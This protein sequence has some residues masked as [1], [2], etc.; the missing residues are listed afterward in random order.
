MRIIMRHL[1]PRQFT[2][3][4]LACYLLACP[5]LSPA[6]EGHPHHDHHQPHD[7]DA[8]NAAAEKPLPRVLILGDSISMG[9]TPHV[10]KLLDGKAVV[11]RPDENCGP[12][13]RGLERLDDWLGDATWDAIHFNFGLHDLKYINAQ[14]DR[15]S[16]D[17]GL[18]QVPVEQYQ[19]NLLEIVKRLRETQAKLIWCTTTP[20]PD[21]ALGRR[22]GDAKRYNAAAANVMRRSLGEER[23]I[24]DLYSFALA[25]QAELQRPADVHFT[26]EGSL[27]LAQEVAAVIERTLSPEPVPTETA[28][29]VVYHDQNANRVFDSGDVPLPDVRV[30]NGHDIV[31]T[32]SEGRYELAVTSDAVVFVIKPRGYRTP[33]DDKQ[34]PQFYYVHKPNGSPQ[35]HFVG[36][37][38]TGPLPESIDFPLYP[39][40]EPDQFKAIMFG[41]PQPRNQQEVDFMA[42]DVIEELV[43]TDA[44][45]GVTLGD[46]AFDNLDVF[47]PQARAIALLGIPWYNVIGNHDINYDAKRDQDSD[48][49]FTRVFGPNYYSF[50]YG[51]V[52]FLVLDDIEWLIDEEGEGRYQGGLGPRQMEFIR[53]DLAMIPQDQL[54]VLMMHIPLVNVR[55]RE[56][57]FRLIEKRPFCMSISAH[58]H[59]HQHRYLTREDG[60]RGPEPHHHVINVTVSGSW[61]AGL[62]DDRGIPHT[63]MADGGPNGYSVMTFD[64]HRYR[65]DFKAAGRNKDYQIG[66]Y[67]PEVVDPSDHPTMDVYA[68]V[69]NGSEK[70]EVLIEVAQFPT[71]PMTYA[72]V[73]DPAYVAVR[74]M[75]TAWRDKLL[76]QGVPEKELWRELPRPARSSHLWQ[77]TV[78]LTN[79][80]DGTHLIRVKAMLGEDQEVAGTR[81]FRIE[82]AARDE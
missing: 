15:V 19:A 20:V 73:E 36:V 54:V 35:Q 40:P 30:S 47:E 56:E 26:D 31:T 17:D 33:V 41:D 10:Q 4:F 67:T 28:R 51:T 22:Q 53:R 8:K 45:F 12:T 69:F 78:D 7:Q 52:H 75:E 48:E 81:L 50:D 37:A 70:S 61:W 2:W 5:A 9:Y 44:S 57:L 21:G 39:Q 16:P 65:I 6:H 74:E 42:H 34:L 23:I 32:D 25:R 46:I 63:T 71:A 27:A 80:P 62:P 77:H 79:I 58:A 64:G 3:L 60:W 72:R 66:I 43:G 14:G 18:I 82:R 38:P 68:N 11:V 76:A 59:I 1:A 49:T 13:T 55:D 29:G 24:H